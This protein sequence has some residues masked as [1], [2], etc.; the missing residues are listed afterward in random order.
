MKDSYLAKWLNDELSTEELRELRASPDFPAYERIVAAMAD[1]RGPDYDVEEALGRIRKARKASQPRV[2]QFR[3]WKKWAA[4]AAV[5]VL[6]VSLSILYVGSMGETIQAPNARQTA[7]V[8]PDESEVVLNAGSEIHYDKRNWKVE[9][10]VKLRGEA[11]FKVSKGSTFSVDTE[12]G[13]VTVLGTQFNVRQ[14]TGYFE[15]SCYEGKVQVSYG[16]SRL[17]LTAGKSFL[18]IEGEII[19]IPGPRLSR[20]SWMDHES[21][22]QSTP[23]SYVLKELE[24]QFDLKVDTRNID[25]SQK[26]T[27]SF[28]NTNLNLALQSISAPYE[29]SFTLEGNKVLFYAADTP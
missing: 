8:L 22:F 17:E 9:R 4:A 29:I 6:L 12:G 20:P 10:N 2:I 5:L 25:L 11:F 7:F 15:V 23:L 14:R 24:R 16:Q 1:A 3:P 26:F 18:A 21:S 19:S 27:G 28:S 13:E